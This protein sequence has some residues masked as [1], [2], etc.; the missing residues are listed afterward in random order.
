[1]NVLNEKD[2]S[3]QLDDYV[4]RMQPKRLDFK[5]LFLKKFSS[6]VMVCSDSDFSLKEF[7]NID[8]K[9][10]RVLYFDLLKV[11]DGDYKQVFNRI[12]QFEPDGVLF[13]NIDKIPN[14][15]EKE[16]FEFLV[17]MALKRD[18][19]PFNQGNGLID[20]N[21][22]MVGAKCSEFPE[23]LKGK[24]LQIIIISVE[25]QISLFTGYEDI[26]TLCTK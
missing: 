12:Y 24:S 23:Y 7:H 14:I 25:N 3:N 4:D 22:L 19:L 11:E 9:E 18:E 16:D 1:M 5:Y 21:A 26:K 8:A 17:Q 2:I 20:F 13:D 10:E 6:P 15:S